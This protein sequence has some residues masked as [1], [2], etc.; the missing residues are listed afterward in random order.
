MRRPVRSVRRLAGLVAVALA[1]GL[2]PQA[3]HAASG[4]A[5]ATTPTAQ[6]P[7]NGFSPTGPWNTPLP[8]DVPLAP[9]SQAIVSN[10]VQ[11]ARGSYGLWAVNTDT[12]SAPIYSV[13]ADTPTTTWTYSDC[14]NLP[15]LAPVIAGSLADVP[16]P[17]GMLVSQGTDE[18]VAIYQPSTD[19]YWDFWRARQDANGNWSA[20]WGGKI[21]HYSANPGIFD[22]PLGASAS[23]LP[24][25]AYLIR[26]DELA[27]GH[28]DH[29][30]NLET[31]HT[32]AN[33]FSWPATRDDGNTA[34][35]DYPCEGQRFRLDPGFNVNTLL[36][37]AAR[38]IA[39]AMQQ[40]GLILT[41]TAGALVTQAQ[42]PRPLEAANGGA[43]PYDK[44]FDPTG[45]GILPESVTRYLVLAGIPINRLQALPLD[46][47]EPTG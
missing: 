32:R 4:T 23:G 26:A 34:G 44:L 17:A 22:N 40:Y 42:D 37:P 21:E 25:G 43:D 1:L 5:T 6:H 35:A 13:D 27:R 29:A 28:I 41:D 14:Q 8:A 10:L 24:F 7:D 33:C 47:G 20:C 11:D 2:S 19:T 12:Y 38:T 15:Q 30:I 31:V 16:T 45:T 9:N 3:S 18:T 39:R 46:Y 36:N